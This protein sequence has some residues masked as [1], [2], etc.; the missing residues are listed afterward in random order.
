M[1]DRR[2]AFHRASARLFLQQNGNERSHDAGGEREC[3][4]AACNGAISDYAVSI[5]ATS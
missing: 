1:A 5:N 3:Y 2:R 4:Q